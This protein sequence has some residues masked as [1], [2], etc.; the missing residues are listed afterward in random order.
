M[1]LFKERIGL[2]IQYWIFHF[3]IFLNLFMNYIY[4]WVSDIGFISVWV[5]GV[6]VGVG[7]GVWVCVGVS[8]KGMS[9]WGGGAG[10]DP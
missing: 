9:Q 8:V 10:H 5:G 4:V 2:E 1:N 6:G 3:L 7:V